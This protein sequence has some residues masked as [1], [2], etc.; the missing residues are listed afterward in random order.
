ME[1]KYICQKMH[2]ILIT[3]HHRQLLLYSDDTKNLTLFDDGTMVLSLHI[4]LCI[5]DSYIFIVQQITQN[6]RL[7]ILSFILRFILKDKHEEYRS[8]LI[9][10]S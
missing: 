5:I 10:N 1:H 6:Q 4:A 2:N 9:S 8:F 7:F 3:K